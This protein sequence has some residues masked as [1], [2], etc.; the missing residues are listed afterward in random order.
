MRIGC[1][2]ADAEGRDQ[3]VPAAISRPRDAST[4]TKARRCS[5]QHY[6]KTQAR[7]QLNSALDKLRAIEQ[8]LPALEDRLGKPLPT[9]SGM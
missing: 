8:G 5:S 1:V 2:I 9:I 4:E 6:F 7:D 3:D